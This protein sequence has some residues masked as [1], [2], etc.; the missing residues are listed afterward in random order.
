MLRNHGKYDLLINN[1]GIGVSSSLESID[2]LIFKQAF[3]VNVFGLSLFS[4]NCSNM[5]TRN[6]E[7]LVIWFYS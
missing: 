2:K 5:K 4:K 1:A 6:Q 7:Q 3:N